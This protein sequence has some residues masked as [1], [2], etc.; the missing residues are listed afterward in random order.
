MYQIP[1]RSPKNSYA[2]FAVQSVTDFHR[3]G[4]SSQRQLAVVSISLSVYLSLSFSIHP[5]QHPLT[6][7]AEPSRIAR[8]LT[9]GNLQEGVAGNNRAAM[10]ILNDVDDN[11]SDVQEEA[12]VSVCMIGTGEYTT[13]YV[14]GGASDSDKGAGGAKGELNACWYLKPV[15]WIDL[16]FLCFFSFLQRKLASFFGRTSSF[17]AATATWFVVWHAV[18]AHGKRVMF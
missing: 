14:H 2:Q 5:T 4:S 11:S 9:G 1:P 6:G 13:G 10:E 18:T 3:S 7:M 16:F 17:G 15:L 12:P 8:Q